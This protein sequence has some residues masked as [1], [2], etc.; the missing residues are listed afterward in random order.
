MIKRGNRM[1]VRDITI[2]RAVILAE[3]ILHCGLCIRPCSADANELQVA[4]T[5]GSALRVSLAGI[6]RVF[7]RSNS[8]DGRSEN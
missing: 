4:V 5:S 8:D 3:V 7:L 6:L 2:S 1:R